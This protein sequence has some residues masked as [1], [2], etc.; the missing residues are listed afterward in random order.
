MDLFGVI[1]FI[2]DV[3]IRMPDPVALFQEFF[4]VRISWTGCWDIFRP[5]IMS[6]SIDRDRCFQEPFSGFTGSPGIVVA[7]VRAGEPG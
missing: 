3:K 5:L 6:I 4:G 7:G 2:R 1:S